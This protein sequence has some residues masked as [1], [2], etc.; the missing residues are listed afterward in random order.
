LREDDIDRAE[1]WFGRHGAKAVFFG[2]LLPVIRTFI[3]LPAGFARMPAGRFG[4]YTVAGCIP[5]T[6]ALGWA[7]YAVGANWQSISAA[8]HGPTYALA[9][10]TG[11]L[12]VIGL[13]VLIRRRRHER[14]ASKDYEASS[15]SSTSSSPVS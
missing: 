2:R 3:S 15:T 5:W 1:R 4:L 14:T 10:I 7:G 8:F 6:L 12:I 9:A 11:I 13:V